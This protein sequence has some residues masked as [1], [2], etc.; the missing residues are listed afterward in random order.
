[1]IISGGCGVV[2]HWNWGY[3]PCADTQ[4]EHWKK[5]QPQ[6]SLVETMDIFPQQFRGYDEY[7]YK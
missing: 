2:I 3:T 6:R 5:E 7:I 1:M 4:F